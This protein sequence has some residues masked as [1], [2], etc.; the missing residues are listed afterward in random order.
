[1]NFRLNDTRRF[2]EL[3][4]F[5]LFSLK[6]ERW[7]FQ[8]ENRVGVGAVPVMSR[9]TFHPFNVL[10]LPIVNRERQQN[11]SNLLKLAILSQKNDITP[12]VRYVYLY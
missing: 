7:D 10:L 5:L 8:V 6:A 9:W 1:M 4:S 2:A 3:S 11:P 12:Y